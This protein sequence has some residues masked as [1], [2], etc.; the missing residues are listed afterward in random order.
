MITQLFII[1]LLEELKNWD[2][3][4]FMMPGSTETAILIGQKTARTV[5][6]S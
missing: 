1:E 5:F 2:F 4:A 3:Y 6:S